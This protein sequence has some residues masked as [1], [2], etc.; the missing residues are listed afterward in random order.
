MKKIA[1]IFLAFL[2]LGLINLQA[3][4]K[5]FEEKAKILSEKIEKITTEERSVLKNEIKA[6]NN[7][8]EANE[9][10]DTEAQQLKKNAAEKSA[11]NI[12]Q[13]VSI[14]EKQLQDLIQHKVDNEIFTEDNRRRFSIGGFDVDYNR[15][16]MRRRHT[17]NYR[18]TTSYTVLAYGLNNLV[19]DNSLSSID[20]SEFSFWKSHFFELGVNYKTRVFK[21][22]SLVY[23]DYGLSV[24][25]NTLKAKNNQFF[26]VDESTA[27]LQTHNE[28]L[29]KSKFKNVQLVVPVFLELDFSKPKLTDEDDKVRYRTNRGFRVGAGG[30]VGVNI[31]TKQTLK[32]YEN[33]IKF[34]DIQKGDFNVNNFIYGLSAFIGHKDTS[35]YV[36]YNLNELFNNALLEQNNISFGVRFD[37]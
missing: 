37:W 1:N 7:Q 15:D 3:Q 28:D 17:R 26:V 4:E 33:D 6:I 5:T 32:Y 14:V 13:R 25:Y 21:N 23:I 11:Q 36:K 10:S 2:F 27:S 18:R 8:L 30:F 34:K 9:I 29:D 20:D 12:Q 24:M 19:N 31:K 16:R 22:S 35:F